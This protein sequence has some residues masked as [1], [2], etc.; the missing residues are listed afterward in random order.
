MILG[1][2]RIVAMLGNCFLKVLVCTYIYIYYCRGCVVQLFLQS[3]HVVSLDSTALTY[4]FF[5]QAK[6]LKSL[7]HKERAMLHGTYTQ[8][9][10]VPY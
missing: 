6:S 2:A 8:K 9:K 1:Q 4:E 3:L 5:F 7:E 10:S